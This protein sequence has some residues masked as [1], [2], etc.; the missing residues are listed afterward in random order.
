MRQAL[1]GTCFD[2][3]QDF[4]TTVEANRYL[5]M[6]AQH[7]SNWADS[8]KQGLFLTTDT[9]TPTVGTAPY[10]LVPFYTTGF[11]ISRGVVPVRRVVAVY[12]TNYASPTVVPLDLINAEDRHNHL[13][14]AA[15]ELPK[16]YLYNQSLGV[17]QGVAGITLLMEYSAALPP[18]TVD[19]N[20]PGETLATPLGT[21][22]LLPVEYHHLIVTYATHL[23]LKAEASP[24]ADGWAQ[25][26]I[27]QRDCLLATLPPRRKGAA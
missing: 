9:F 22:D 18:M 13:L 24:S 11:A 15:V 26:Y 20:T 16:V 1:L 2:F 25:T 10:E 3:S 19:A 6:A 12:R 7:V 17:V 4:L 27:E 14:E 21:Q 8:L 5:N 23:A